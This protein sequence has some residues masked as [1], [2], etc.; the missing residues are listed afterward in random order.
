MLCEATQQEPI[1]REVAVKIV[2]PDLVGR[3]LVSRFHNE[4]RS[5][6]KMS[7]PH[8]ATVLDG[9]TTADG[10]PYLVME[11]VDGLGVTDFCQQ[12]GVGIQGRLQL[13]LKVCAGVQHAHQ[14]GIIH[15]DIKPS[16]ILVAEIDG[17]PVPKV[18][19]FGLAKVLADN[20]PEQEQPL[21]SSHT[22]FGQ[23]LGT[24]QY[25]SPEQASLQADR[26]DIRSD[27]FALGILLFEL[28]TGSTPLADQLPAQI[29]IDERLR[30]VHELPW[31]TMCNVFW[32]IDQC[33]RR[34]HPIGKSY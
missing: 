34:R 16:N 23:I 14:K 1:P 13:F 20:E 15:R 25:M 26:V 19:D 21:A 7:H 18:I 2:K 11:L 22:Q 32:N 3:E 28:L 4:R 9:G 31:Q 6:A 33:T 17:T 27:V 24:L 30:R 12:Y 29:P 8:V 10:R 5:L